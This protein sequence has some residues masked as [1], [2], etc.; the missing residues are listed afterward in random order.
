MGRCPTDPDAV[1]IILAMLKNAGYT[2]KG[3]TDTNPY[4]TIGK[5]L[6][7]NVSL[8]IDV[9][10]ESG[11][12]LETWVLNNAM[13]I[14]ADLGQ[15]DYSSDDLR[16]LTVTFKYDWATCTFGETKLPEYFPAQN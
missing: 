5:K 9:L 7:A 2:V 1:S 11:N 4:S 15:M 10:D 6:A 3:L 8:T 12:I 14:S 13:L 16:E